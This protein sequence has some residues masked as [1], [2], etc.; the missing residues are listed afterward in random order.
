MSFFSVVAPVCITV[1]APVEM[2]GILLAVET[3]PD[4]FRTVGNVTADIAA[5]ASIGIEGDDEPPGQDFAPA[6]A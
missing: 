6:S 3:I 5:V 1:G 2:L 4:I